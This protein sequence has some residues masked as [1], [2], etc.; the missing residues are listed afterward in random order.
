MNLEFPKSQK[1]L[2]FCQRI[3]KL[4]KESAKLQNLVKIIVYFKCE[5][6]ML[7]FVEESCW[8]LR[9]NRHNIILRSFIYCCSSPSAVKTVL[10]ISQ[11]GIN[12]ITL[13]KQLSNHLN[14]DII[15]ASI[16]LSSFPF[17]GCFHLSFLFPFSGYFQKFLSTFQ[18][19][20]AKFLAN[21]RPRNQ[22]SPGFN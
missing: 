11:N 18:A 21:W 14:V 15:N 3:W 1:G 17:S 2:K 4:N 10:S 22:L 7:K 19:Q 5:A 6:V 13:N 8:A 20:V 12:Q 9:I 16:S